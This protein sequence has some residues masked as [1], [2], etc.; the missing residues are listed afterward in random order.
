MLGIFISLVSR[1]IFVVFLSAEY[2]GLNGLFSNLLSM[3]SLAELGV[4]A[5]IVYSLYK[6]IAENNVS[7]IKSLMLLYKKTYTAVGIFILVSG[8]SLTPFLQLFIKE[9]PAIPNIKLI[10]ICLLYTSD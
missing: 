5:A 3:L 6:P 4:G 1:R 9:M 2:L 10:Y 8:C 7:E